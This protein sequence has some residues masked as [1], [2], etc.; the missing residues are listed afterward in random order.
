[1]TV[2]VDT[3]LFDEAVTVTLHQEDLEMVKVKIGKGE[4]ELD[5]D[6]LK[7]LIHAL[8]LA[9]A[10]QTGDPSRGYKVKLEAEE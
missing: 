6:D 8:S 3:R 9:Q 4:V 10:H 7:L 5:S 1:M 2:L